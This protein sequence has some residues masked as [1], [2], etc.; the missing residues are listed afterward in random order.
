MILLL[1]TNMGKSSHPK[2]HSCLQIV[3][4]RSSMLL[5][6]PKPPPSFIF[7]QN[8]PYHYP[9]PFW[10]DD[11]FLYFSENIRDVSENT[12]TFSNLIFIWTYP[13]LLSC[14]NEKRC[15][16]SC[17]GTIQDSGSHTLLPALGFCQFSHAFCLPSPHLLTFFSFSSV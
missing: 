5:D 3:S 10:Q 16:F 17:P 13:L 14:I 4:L 11:C 8:P 6:N 9:P 2:E 12:L 15:P 1:S 7:L